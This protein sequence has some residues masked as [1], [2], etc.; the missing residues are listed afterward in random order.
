MK[1]VKAKRRNRMV[2]CYRF[3]VVASRRVTTKMEESD[4]R[5]GW[6]IRDS[7]DEQQMGAQLSTTH[8][9]Q[10]SHSLC[11]ILTPHR[12]THA[13]QRLLHLVY[14]TTKM[15]RPRSYTFLQNQIR[16]GHDTHISD[17]RR[18]GACSLG[19]LDGDNGTVERW[20]WF[21]EIDSGVWCIA[22]WTVF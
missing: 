4:W 19:G 12:Q 1:G 22:R 5:R 15:T 14:T 13:H 10:P 8:R 20:S 16:S 9:T 3:V 21:G 6:V 2:L 17:P 11:Y 7:E 18:R